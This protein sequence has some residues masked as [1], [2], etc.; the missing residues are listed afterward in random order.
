VPEIRDLA[1]QAARH[2]LAELDVE[3]EALA[4]D[5]AVAGAARH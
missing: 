2:L 4:D 5:R 3:P 1:A